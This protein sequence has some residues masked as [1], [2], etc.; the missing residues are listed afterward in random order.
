MPLVVHT[1]PR[2]TYAGR[3]AVDVTPGADD[4]LGRSLDLPAAERARLHVAW[5]RHMAGRAWPHETAGL[6][7]AVVRSVLAGARPGG[8]LHLLV[9]ALSRLAPEVTLVCD[10]DAHGGGRC[11]RT[12]TASALCSALGA[13]AVFGG[14]RGPLSAAPPG[15]ARWEDVPAAFR[16]ADFELALR[17]AL[18]GDFTPAGHERPAPPPPPPP[19]SRAPPGMSGAGVPWFAAALGISKWPVTAAELEAARREA[20]FSAHP[21]RGG[22]TE[23]FA[24]ARSAHKLAE[25]FLA[26]GLPWPCGL[27]DVER[28]AGR[29]A[30]AMALEGLSA[31]DPKFA[32]YSARLELIQ[33]ALV[34]GPKGRAP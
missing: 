1:A 26:F 29:I 8:A 5:G 25:A 20:V 9:A 21:D 32:A 19:P 34:A 28:A 24:A 4:P 12:P 2:Q 27:A 7:A 14:E 6:A 10:C 15:A 18:G 17:V 30:A 16:D 3:D 22:S 23:R 11:L 33:A 31:D 13:S